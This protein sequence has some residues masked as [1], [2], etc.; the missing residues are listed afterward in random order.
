MP[1]DWTCPH[2]KI[3]KNSEEE[4]HRHLKMYHSPKRK[5]EGARRILDFLDSLRLWQR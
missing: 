1:P 5:R 4:F 2:C 3:V